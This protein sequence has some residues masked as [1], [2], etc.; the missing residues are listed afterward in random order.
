MT[1]GILCKRVNLNIFVDNKVIDI[2]DLNKVLGFLLSVGSV[3][4]LVLEIA[5]GLKMF[6]I[7]RLN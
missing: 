7:A 3:E 1:L 5:R 6:I 2:V 4:S